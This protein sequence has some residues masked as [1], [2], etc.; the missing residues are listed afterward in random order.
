MTYLDNLIPEAKE[1]AETAQS[2]INR[3][4]TQISTA[5]ENSCSEEPTDITK[6]FGESYKRRGNTFR[7]EDPV[8]PISI[9]EQTIQK[10][11]ELAQKGKEFN[12]EYIVR[13][14]KSL[15]ELLSDIYDL[16]ITIDKSDHKE[17]V[18]K[19]LRTILKDRGQKIQTNTS[20]LTILVKYV[21]GSDRKRASNYSR[22]LDIAMKENLA[23]DELVDYIS[24]RGGISQI[25][26][27]ESKYEAKRLGTKISKERLNLCRELF[28]YNYWTSK[29]SFK[30]DE[31]I[32]Q[33]NFDKQNGAET[34]SFCFF[35]TIY[36]QQN[37][38]YRIID[39]HDFGKSY[40]DSILRMIIKTYPNDLS[41]IKK[42]LERFKEGLLKLA[43]V[44][45][46]KKAILKKELATSSDE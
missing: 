25:H 14:N 42:G 28:T 1:R 22:V 44:P 15:Y 5:N 19:R 34:A 6:W 4:K 9:V 8:K 20:A 46:W 32:L 7:P 21:V 37:D 27:V 13:G 30:Y 12:D 31:P 17:T 16:A 33:H 36:D 40:E 11:D 3:I 24:R 18:L 45:D 26:E 39:G 35:M 2:L 29:G 23:S 41:I 43:T 10:C 38:E